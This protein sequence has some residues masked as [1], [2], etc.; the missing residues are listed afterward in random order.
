MIRI[1]KKH[2]NIFNSYIIEINYN[3]YLKNIKT[4]ILMRLNFH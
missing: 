3:K 1:N 4:Q 2:L